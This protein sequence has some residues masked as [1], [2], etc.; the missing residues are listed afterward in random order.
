ME[1]IVDLYTP[2]RI[3]ILFR[4]IKIYLSMKVHILIV[5]VVLEMFRRIK[6]SK[7]I[8]DTSY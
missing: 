6:G 1:Y 8:M 5:N 3:I 7:A 4:I 2:S